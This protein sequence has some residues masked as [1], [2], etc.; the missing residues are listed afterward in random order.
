MSSLLLFAI[1]LLFGIIFGLFWSKT[2][3]SNGHNKDRSLERLLRERLSK[4]DNEI[5]SLKINLDN[6]SNIIK[7]TREDKENLRNKITEIN[8]QIKY[9]EKQVQF[10]NDTRSDLQVQ[11]KALTHEMLKESREEL[12]RSNNAKVTEPFSQ[13]MAKLTKQVKTLSDESK[14]KLA[15]LAETTKALREKNEDVK[16]AALELANALRSPNIKGKWGEV[17]LKRTMEY[18]GLK[19]YCD[20]DEQVTLVTN[21]GTY[22]PDCIL[23]IPGRRIFIVDSK[24]PIDSY[25]EIFKAKDEKTKSFALDNHVRKLRN[26]IDQLSKKDYSNNLRSLG[27]VLDGVIMFIPIE[28]ALSMALSHDEDLLEYAFDKKIILTFPTSFLAILKNL[29]VNINQSELNND[30]RSVYS[31]ANDLNN[32]LSLFISK[33]NDIGFKIRKLGKSYNDAL[34]TFKGNL[35]PKSKNFAE[36]S[37]KNLEF[38]L[39]EEIEESS[40]REIKETS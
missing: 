13:E 29:S 9:K 10:F 23:K 32:S 18:V 37:A 35:L 30:L 36:L 25:D 17:T 12:I 33:F 38:N 1:G 27:S 34:G 7:V 2:F 3:L 20:F 14:E 5:D 19:K 24:T 39:E 6:L 11:F 22:R 8:E 40:I 15:F 21:D 26:H 28:G 31:K 16:G 4:A